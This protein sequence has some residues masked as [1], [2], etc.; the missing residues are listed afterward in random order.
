MKNYIVIGAI[1]IAG[2]TF[3]GFYG[4]GYDKFGNKTD[5]TANESRPANQ[6]IAPGK[7]GSQRNFRYDLKR[8]VEEGRK[9]TRE[10]K[11]KIL[12]TGRFMNSM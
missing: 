9:Q 5:P 6:I 2:T 11:S 8:T 4:D 7:G 1:L 10:Q 3:A 12:Y